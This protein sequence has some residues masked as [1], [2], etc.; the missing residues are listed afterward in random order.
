MRNTWDE[1]IG[2]MADATF[3]AILR[4]A[5][6]MPSVRKLA[7]W[8]FGEPL[9]HPRIADMVRRADEAGYETELITN[10]LLLT[11][12]VSESLIHAGLGTVVVS[13]DGVSQESHAD[14]REGA[15]LGL[16]QQNIRALNA[17]RR[18]NARRNPE[19]GIEFVAMKRNIADLKNLPSLA[20]SLEAGFIIVTNV[21]PYSEGLKDEILYWLSAG[22][23]YPATRSKWRP[24][25]RLPRFDARPE[26]LEHLRGLSSYI[27]TNGA[28]P[29]P[30]SGIDGYC[31][32]VWEG[33]V[34]VAWDGG[35]SPCVALMHSYTCYIL[36]RAKKIRRH[37]VGN[38]GARRLSSIWNDE[39]F[40]RFRRRVRD[41]EFSPCVSCGGCDMAETNEEDCIGSTFPTC[42]DCLWAR[43]ILLCP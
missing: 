32:F 25:V 6:D 4:G 11:P 23:I 29:G 9:M 35:V 24:D 15:D 40:V 28:R 20:R 3:D 16:V 5:K 43:D 27:S 1:P 22:D 37:A 39:D 26:I 13:L 31:P 30:G 42:G 36:D 41:F 10:G 21:L 19:L 33:S 34:S 18:R 38:I 2:E 17:A 12:E 7:F 14:I 8:G